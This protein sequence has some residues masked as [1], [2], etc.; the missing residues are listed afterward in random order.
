MGREAG[1]QLH[2]EG[3]KDSRS[4]TNVVRI[5]GK[6]ARRSIKQSYA[7]EEPACSLLALMQDT[8]HTTQLTHVRENNM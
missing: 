4:S 8:I 5:G 1:G 6:Q 2:Q 7:E 3:G